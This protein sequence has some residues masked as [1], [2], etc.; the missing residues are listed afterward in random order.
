VREAA[1]TAARFRTP[2][3]GG[4]IM[5][6]T[7]PI[8]VGVFPGYA[9]AR[10]AVEELRKAGFRDDQIGVLGPNLGELLP[11]EGER[12]GLPNDPLGTHWEEGAGLGAAAGATAGLGLGLAVAA[13]L[14]PPVGPVIAGGT[15]VALLASAG[16]GATAGTVVGGILGLG[17]PE[18]H[19]HIYEG[20]LRAGRVLVAVRPADG[21]DE[22][23]HR[24]LRELGGVPA[25]APDIGT[26]GTGVP[27]TPY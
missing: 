15:L 8:R 23:A 21:Q 6:T 5:T 18:D 1:P 22:T 2:E 11:A 27:A 12:S 25:G 14:M 13:G 19:A 24:V 17:V 9:E 3:R 4:E 7:H 26:Y 20:E 10:R 16:A